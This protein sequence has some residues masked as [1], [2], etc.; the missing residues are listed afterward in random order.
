MK[1]CLDN[2]RTTGADIRSELGPL[3]REMFLGHAQATDNYKSVAK[4]GRAIDDFVTYFCGVTRNYAY[5]IN[6]KDRL[7]PDHTKYIL[8]MQFDVDY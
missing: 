5:A 2:I 6:I 4:E 8:T 1:F 3:F 7:S